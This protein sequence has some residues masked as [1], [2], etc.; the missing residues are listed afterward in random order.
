MNRPPPRLGTVRGQSEPRGPAPRNHYAAQPINNPSKP[1]RSAFAATRAP[2][3]RETT[4]QNQYERDP[5]EDTMDDVYGMYASP[6]PNVRSQRRPSQHRPREPY[7][8]NEVDED[9]YIDDSEV[10]AEEVAAFEPASIRSPPRRSSSRSGSG[11]A[12]SKSSRRSEM[13]KIRIK[14]HDADDTRY[15][16]MPLTPAGRSMSVDF[17]DFEARIREKFGVK[18]VLKIKI[19]EEDGDMITMGDQDDLDVCMHTVKGQA[20]KERSDMGKMEVWISY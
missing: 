15:I 10:T 9:E 1:S 19:K 11:A 17:G 4:P 3:F 6:Q 20:R 12:S 16:M 13:K 8:F 18:G 14:V 2:L 7:I 5:A